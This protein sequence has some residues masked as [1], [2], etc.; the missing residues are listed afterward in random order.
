MHN[1]VNFGSSDNRNIV[2]CLVD[3]T[4]LISDNWAKE[5]T[6][7][8]SDYTISNLVGK[9]YNIIQGLDED[10]LLR[11]AAAEYNFAVVFSTGTEFINGN[12]FFI[13]IE[14]LIEEDFFVA[15]HILDRKDVTCMFLSLDNQCFLMLYN[16][17]IM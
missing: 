17:R 1:L 12:D 16:S 11:A 8:I 10:Q 3:R 2:C 14:K 15:G 13:N 6:K 5:V 4:S 7:N 9:G